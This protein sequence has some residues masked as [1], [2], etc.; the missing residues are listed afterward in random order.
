M[1]FYDALWRARFES[2]RLKFYRAQGVHNT[3][4]RAPSAKHGVDHKKKAEA[5]SDGKV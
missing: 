5:V 2:F 4:W 1:T 3:H